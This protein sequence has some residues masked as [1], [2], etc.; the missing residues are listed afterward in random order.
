MAFIVHFKYQGGVYNSI[1][2]SI[3]C[4][5]FVAT[6][7][8][9]ILFFLTRGRNTLQFLMK[10]GEANYGKPKNF[11]LTINL[12]EKATTFLHNTIIIEE[13]LVV[14]TSHFKQAFCDEKDLLGDDRIVCGL[15]V[16]LWYPFKIPYANL[17]LSIYL[18][19]FLPYLAAQTCGN[20]LYVG[21]VVPILPKI[22]H[23]KDFLKAIDFGDEQRSH[24]TMK[25][26]S[27]YYSDILELVDQMNET[28]GF[29]MSPAQNV[30]VVVMVGLL[31]Y[32]AVMDKNILAAF[33]LVI[34]LIIQFISCLSGQILENAS[35][36]ITEC[37]YDMKWY[38]MHPSLRNTFKILQGQAQQTMHFKIQPLI[39]MNMEYFYKVMQSSYSFL[40]FLSNF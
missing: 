17:I 12:A 11:D 40:M 13:I 15:M 39:T 34:W 29:I 26:C 1:L 37:V 18:L 5:N 10:L 6:V 21:S 2:Y 19:F 24:E 38:D 30:L 14:I 35:L 7:Q 25:L 20:I 9:C 28:V 27:R 36:S 32:Q 3:Y 4:F 8:A 16:P 22:E 31:E 23:L 33:Q